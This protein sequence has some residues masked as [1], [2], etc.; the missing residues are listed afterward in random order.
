MLVGT[1]DARRNT[2][3]RTGLEYILNANVDLTIRRVRLLVAERYTL[4]QN[5]HALV[6][7]REL[8]VLIAGGRIDLQAAERAGFDFELYAIDVRAQP[9]P[10]SKRDETLVQ[11]ML[12]THPAR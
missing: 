11:Q 9:V 8:E 7:L 10:L 5:V 6:E 3:G 2:A 1:V 4:N 12:K